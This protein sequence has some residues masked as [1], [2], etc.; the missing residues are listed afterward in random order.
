M[1][2]ELSHFTLAPIES[3]RTQRIRRV[4][5]ILNTRKA[6][7]MSE[8]KKICGYTHVNS[9]RDLA[10]SIAYGHPDR[11]CITPNKENAKTV[12]ETRRLIL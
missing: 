2:A 11:L 10:E 4:V 3:S 12:T 9:A 8:I 1:S 5:T 7:T 6:L